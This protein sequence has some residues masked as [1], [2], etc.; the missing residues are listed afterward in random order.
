MT[1]RNLATGVGFFVV[2]VVVLVVV[3]VGVG[4]GVVEVIGSVGSV[5]GGCG[6]LIAV[7]MS[8]SLIRFAGVHDVVSGSSGESRSPSLRFVAPTGWTE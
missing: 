1:S 7:P 5:F 8:F 2:V 6:A 4:V 3:V